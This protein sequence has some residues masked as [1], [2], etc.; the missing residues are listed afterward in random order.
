[1]FNQRYPT[2]LRYLSVPISI[3]LAMWI[4]WLLDPLLGD[5][6]ALA[7]VFTAIVFTAWYGG[8][9]PALLTMILGYVAADYCFIPPR[10]SLGVVDAEFLFRYAVVGVTTALLGGAM[11]LARLRAE[12]SAAKARQQA[13]L[14]DQ[15]HDAMLAWDCQDGI[16]FWNRGAEQMYGYARDQALGRRSHDLLQT[17]LPGGIDGLLRCLHAEQ[18]W[19]GEIS[20][21]TRTGQR[22]WVE[23]RMVLVNEDG[24]SYVIETNRDITARRTLETLRSDMRVQLEQQVQQRTAELIKSEQRYRSLIQATAEVVWR[25]DARGV[26][27][28]NSVAD[29][30]GL[31]AAQILNGDYLQLVAPQ[32]RERVAATWT[33]ARKHGQPFQFEC[34]LRR[35]SDTQWRDK[36]ISAVPIA[37]AAGEVEEWLGICVDVTT[38]KQT[39]RAL[40][41]SEEQ[42]RALIEGIQDYAILMLDADG[43]IRTWS[44]TAE[45][46]G[47]YQAEEIIGQ[48]F[49]KLFTAEDIALGRPERELVQAR[50]AGKQEID[51]WRLHKNGTPYWAAGTLAALR[52]AEDRLFGFVKVMRDITDKRRNDELLRSVLDNTL[53]AIISMD[54]RGNISSFNR[55]GELMFGRE[56]SEVIGQNIRLLM[57]DS[58]HG[59]YDKHLADYLRTGKAAHIA[60]GR[61]LYGLRGDGLTFAMDFAVT[62]FE[63][64]RQQHFIGIL[65]DIS[66][67]KNLEEQLRQSQKLDA[68]GQLAGGVAHDFNNLLLVISGYSSLLMST[69]D[70]NDESHKFVG[71]IRRAGE[72]AAA[73][74][75]QLLAFSR[76]QVLEPRVLDLNEVVRGTERMLMRVIGE[77]VQ[78]NSVLASQISAVKIDPGQLEQVIMNLVVNARDAMPEGGKLSIET[79]E[80]EVDAMYRKMHPQ[81]RPGCFVVLTISDTGQGM[82]AQVRSRIFEPFFTTKAVGKGTGLGLAVVHG[83]VKQS[84]GHIEVHSEP[85]FGTA[86]KIYL[87]AVKEAPV[88]SADIEAP[89][90]DNG[91]ETILLVEDDDSVR[92]LVARSLQSLGYKVM[93]AVNGH[94]ALQ[95]LDTHSA[96]IDLL[97]TDVVMPE[98]TGR[99]LAEEFSTRS[100][101]PVLFV[102]GYTNDAVVRHGVLHAEAAFLHKPFTLKALSSKVRELLN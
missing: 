66:E 55:A 32:Q 92:E 40:S 35:G 33:Q 75:R 8:L 89:Q 95:V 44:K 56:A 78:L 68:F 65:R 11:Q 91:N 69:L 70:A 18:R 2:L 37:N 29:Y 23:T 71:E 41:T 47:G 46:I 53:D 19:E 26:P 12:R 20:H 63:L 3:V 25:T 96:Q 52:D 72:R 5:Q 27:L 14:I 77:Q 30:T 51:G 54:A 61:E 73:L 100:R 57:P 99:E 76:Q 50:M 86:F 83:I 97:L 102:S 10:G 39:E 82:T 90:V 49:S 36:L 9:V 64:D 38:R 62:G 45:R 22:I 87:P 7:T 81:L 67:R 98:M 60:L 48:S 34:S 58:C 17:E 4:R 6:F 101:A 42:F 84:G 88:A 21:R 85:G 31:S 1:M 94:A 15:V 79:A 59:E 43:M 16:T 80:I 74:T 93:Q 28:D 24:R 13:A